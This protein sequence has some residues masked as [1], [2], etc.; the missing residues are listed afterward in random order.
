MPIYLRLRKPILWLVFFISFQGWSQT[1]RQAAGQV[2]S[3]ERANAWYSQ[4]RWITGANFLPSTAINQ[5][6]MWQEESFDPATIDRELGWAEKIGFNSMRVF[7]HSLAWKED[8]EGFKKRVEQYLT[9]ANRH[10]IKTLF[11][12]FDDCWNTIPQAGKQPAPK[13]GVHNSG[14]VQDPGQP[15]S[16]DSTLY[17]QLERYVKD[18][19]TRFA[20]DKHILIW[21]LYN[22]PGN[23]GK[24]DSS[25]P[26]LKKVFQWA[27][28]INPEQPI[29]VGLWAWDLEKLNAFQLLNSDVITYHE[30]EEPQW[31]QRVIE[32]LK[33]NGRP[34]ICTEYMARTRNSRFSNT[35][36]LLKKYNVGAINW[37]FVSG[38]SNTIY[39]W[40][41]PVP[42]G[43]QPVEWFHDIFFTDGTPYRQDE[44]NLIKKLNDKQ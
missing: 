44:I 10:G 23:S 20:K 43:S 11:V 18:V 3:A 7:L 42:D 15:L 29:S 9:I 33:S 30:Y 22:E 27:R 2:W 37:G 13:P 12:F 26:L 35:L 39:A 1:N 38:K 6:E 36:P 5:L 19:M 21:D 4:H 40:D 17:P 14:W 24:K 8:P 25:L 31:H 32:L 34:L 41:T 16:F 28:E